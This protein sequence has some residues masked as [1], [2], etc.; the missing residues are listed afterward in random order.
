[1]ERQERLKYTIKFINLIWVMRAALSK[2]QNK[3]KNLAAVR[4]VMGDG[5]G[6]QAGKVREDGIGLVL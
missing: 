1:M 6:R 3:T 4:R 2:K 5:G